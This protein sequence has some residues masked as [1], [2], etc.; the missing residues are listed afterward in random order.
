[1]ITVRDWNDLR[2]FGI[3]ALTGEAC[4]V[5]KRLLCDVND[6][7]RKLLCS[8]FGFAVFVR[9]REARKELAGKEAIT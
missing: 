5:G 9:L 8:I 3:N 7:G 6:Q 2:S 1:M 4:A